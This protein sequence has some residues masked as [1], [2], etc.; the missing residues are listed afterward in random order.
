MALTATPAVPH[1]WGRW[2][3]QLPHDFGIM[4]APFMPYDSRGNSAQMPRPMP[5]QYVVPPSYSSAPMTSMTTAHYQA[6]NAYA[7]YAPYQSPPPSTPVGSPFKPEFQDRPHPLPMG[8]DSESLRAASSRRTS[9]QTSNARLHSPARSDSNISVAPSA[10]SN[11][12]ANSKTIT[13]NET[14]NPADR[15]N[16]ETDVD[17]LMKAIQSKEEASNEAPGQTLTPAHTPKAEIS[18]DVQ[19]PANSCHAST[20]AS[21]VK[22]KKKWV[23]DGPNCNKRFVQKTHLDIHRRTHTGLKPYICTKDNCGLTFSQRG[24]L[25]TH[26][27]R[28]TGEKPYSCSICGKTFAQRGNVRSHEETHKGLKPFICRLDDCN[29]AF[30]QLGNMKTHQNNFHRETL[31]D[32][33]AMFA[34]FV[35]QGEVPD[36]HQDL[37]EYFKEHYKNS[38]KGIKGRGKAR[39]VA[40]RKPKGNPHQSTPAVPIMANQFSNPHMSNSAPG[41]VARSFGVFGAEHD[42]AAS[43]MLYEDEHAR[44]MAFAN[45]LY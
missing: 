45:R 42:H 26:M 39:T 37:F 2:P 21:E 41:Y 32:L 4:E 12:T 29:K 3:Q 19:S 31:K 16:F 36:E 7:T 10:T 8:P 38:N 40:V 9:R 15:I 14:I 6:Q 11:P 28:H 20:T 35:Q 43:S 33:T 34:R 44:Q 22:P 27:R 1:N 5:P 24:N 13:Y 17:E 25:K 30:S 18:M 23:C